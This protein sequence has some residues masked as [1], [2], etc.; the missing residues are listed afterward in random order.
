MK[1]EY[2]KEFEKTARKL[3]GKSIYFLKVASLM[4]RKQ[5]T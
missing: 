4:L 3:A 2:S 5:R 1:V